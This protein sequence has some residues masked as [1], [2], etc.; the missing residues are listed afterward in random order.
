M[1]TIKLIIISLF[2]TINTQ[3]QNLIKVAVSGNSVYLDNKYENKSK[4][5]YDSVLSFTINSSEI[6]VLSLFDNCKYCYD[7]INFEKVRLICLYKEYPGNR[8]YFYTESGEMITKW[9]GNIYK[10]IEIYPSVSFLDINLKRTYTL[11]NE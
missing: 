9:D 6:F 8:Y 3:S 11:N 4:I 10:R 5:D 2:I 7:S 1:K